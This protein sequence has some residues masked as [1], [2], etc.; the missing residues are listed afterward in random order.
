[1]TATAPMRKLL[2]VAVVL[3]LVILSATASAGTPK[4]IFYNLTTEES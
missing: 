3:T 4:T 2:V 1:M